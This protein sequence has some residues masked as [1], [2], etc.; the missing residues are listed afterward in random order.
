MK[1]LRYKAE[2]LLG[3]NSKIIAD[4]NIWYLLGREPTLFERVK[5]EN[6]CPNYINI[7]ELTN[8]GNIVRKEEAVRLAIQKIFYFQDNAILQPPYA[9]VINYAYPIEYIYPY[10]SFMEIFAEGDRID[11]EKKDDFFQYI[12]FFNSGFISITDKFNTKAKQIRPTV[13]DVEEYRKKDTT[14]LIESFLDMC[15][16]NTTDNEF[17]FNDKE[18][19]DVDLWKRCIDWFF[20]TM[21]IGNMNM[22]Q[23][24]WFDLSLLAYVQ[25]NDKI[26][27]RDKKL[28]QLIKDC[29][30]GKYLYLVPK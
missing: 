16:R 22:K 2:F 6:I 8:T 3:M 10:L 27:T 12:S 19:I 26:W 21:I 30:C 18:I 24:D 11:K 5:S 9:H 7:I 23:N 20:K 28:I 1:V 4:T 17:G 13:N 15:I 29:G 14:K 25:K